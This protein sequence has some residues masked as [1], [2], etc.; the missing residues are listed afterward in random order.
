[1]T[2]LTGIG[3]ATPYWIPDLGHAANSRLRAFFEIVSRD[4]P[5][6]PR[7]GAAYAE[8]HAWSVR[9][10]ASFWTALW[11]FAGI[12]ADERPGRAPW[13]TALRGGDRMAPP[14]HAEGPAWFEGA[15]LNFAENLLRHREGAPALVFRGEGAR[16]RE[17]SLP[18]CAPP[19]RRSRPRCGRKESKPVT[20]WP[21]TS[22]TFLRP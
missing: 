4:E 17:L 13:D 20:A 22:R 18:N 8:W 11:R 3:Q 10:P 6:A 16:R 19:P 7:S 15:R 9:E 21:D 5:S 1:M 14:S 12:V 2:S